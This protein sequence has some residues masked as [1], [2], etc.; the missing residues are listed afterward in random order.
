MNNSTPGPK[1]LVA[2]STD[3]TSPVFQQTGRQRCSSP[4][5]TH[6]PDTEI[7]LEGGES[8]RFYLR[9]RAPSIYQANA[10]ELAEIRVD[11]NPTRIQLSDQKSQ[12]SPSWT[13]FTELIWM[14]PQRC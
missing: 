2:D 10:D 1:D 4:T 12:R 9:V 3:S 6:L 7:F 13:L 14:H 11:A 8:I 5:I